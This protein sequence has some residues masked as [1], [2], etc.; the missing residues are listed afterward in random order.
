MRFVSVSEARKRLDDVRD[1]AQREP[2]TIRHQNREVAVVLSPPDY[3]RLTVTSVVEFQ[4]FCDR[5]SDAARA[6]GFTEENWTSCPGPD[7][8]R[9][10]PLIEELGDVLSREKSDRYVSLAA[11]ACSYA[12]LAERNGP[13]W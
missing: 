12:G 1:Q 10:D 13:Q 6:R 9:S 4:R 3:R 5:V 7:A 8:C 2:V 11:R